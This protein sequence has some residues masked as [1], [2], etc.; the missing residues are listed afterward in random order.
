LKVTE[1]YEG[2]ESFGKSI[3]EDGI[4]IM[5]EA[6]EGQV[7]KDFIQKTGLTRTTNYYG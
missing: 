6:P 7:F 3:I 2:F 1:T 4:V 5:T